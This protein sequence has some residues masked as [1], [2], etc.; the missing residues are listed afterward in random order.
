MS[1]PASSAPGDRAARGDRA[2]TSTSCN[3]SSA[4]AGAP[5]APP[6]GNAYVNVTVGGVTVK[7]PRLSGAVAAVGGPA[8]LLVTRNFMLYS[9]P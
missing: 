7:V 6:A 3:W 8:Y 1:V 2:P 5:I 4:T 9:A